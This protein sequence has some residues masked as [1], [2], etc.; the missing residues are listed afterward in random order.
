[1]TTSSDDTGS[2]VLPIHNYNNDDDLTQEDIRRAHDDSLRLYHQMRECNDGYIADKLHNAM[3]ILTD[4][5][6]LYGPDQLFSSYNGGKDAVV[7]MHIL[8]AVV[9]KY[10]ADHGT[11]FRPKFIYFAVNDEFPEVLDH[12]KHTAKTLALTSLAI[13]VILVEFAATRE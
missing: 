2:Q 7:I 9:A 5:L 1:M 12:I 6:R 10:S 8:R 13:N 4:A 11:I 3:D